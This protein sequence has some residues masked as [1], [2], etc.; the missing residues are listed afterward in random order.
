MI[1]PEVQKLRMPR[2]PGE[3]S[4]RNLNIGGQSQRA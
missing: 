2:L 4:S 1:S 3:C